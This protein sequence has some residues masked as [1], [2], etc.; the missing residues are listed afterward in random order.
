MIALLT[1][2]FLGTAM[3]VHAVSNTEAD[4]QISFAEHYLKEFEKEVDRQKGGQKD[5]YRYQKDALERVQALVQAYPDN[6]KVQAMYVR[7]RTALMKSYGN[8]MEITPDML[9]YK[10]NEKELRERYGTI[11]GVAWQKKMEE[12]KPEAKVFPAPDPMDVSPD[13]QFGNYVVLED[14]RYPG[15]QFYGATGEF[16]HVGQPSS[17]YYFVNIAGRNWLGPYEAVKRFRRQVDA[18]IGDMFA[19]TVLGKITGLVMESPDASLEKKAPFVWGWIVEPELLYLPDKVVAYYDPAHE[20]SGYF[21]KE[22]EVKDIKEGWYTVKSVPD[23]VTPRRLMEIFATAIKE[24]NYE[25]YVDCIRPEWRELAKRGD[26]LYHWDLHQ[27][28]FAEQY[29][30]VTFDEPVIEVTRGF[31]TDD[32]LAG[33]FLDDAQRAHLTKMAGEKREKAT[34]YSRAFDENGRQQNPVPHYLIR[35]GNGRWYVDSY[36]P[37]FKPAF[38]ERNI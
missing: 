37:V 10:R 15:N 19:F 18:S 24:K 1:G 17:G 22:E 32:N 6:P 4:R 14:V 9:A 7:T 28:R 29:V 27:R 36:A 8:Y 23:D 35:T 30:A 12:L 25:L 3:P 2:V 11:S 20:N 33:F 38:L 31:N 34:V 5:R 26:V 16:I 13:E 21:E